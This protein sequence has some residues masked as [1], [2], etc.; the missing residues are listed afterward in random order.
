MFVPNQAV[1]VSS[2][3][4]NPANIGGGASSTGTIILS[5]AAPAGG[6]SVLLT[7]GDSSVTVPTS[8]VVAAGTKTANFS[9]TTSTVAVTTAVTVTATYNGTSQTAQLTLSP[10]GQ[11]SLSSVSVTPVSVATGL[12]ATGTVT[13]SG[14]APSGGTVIYLWTNG[15]PAFVP[16]SI[17]IPAGAPTGTFPVTTNYVTTAT[18]GTITAFYNGSSKTT[19][20][21]VTP[22]PTLLSVVIEDP[23][24]NGDG[25]ETGFVTLTE[26]APAGGLLVYLWTFGSPVFVP[27]SVTVPAGSLAAVFRVTS[28]DVASPTQ[29]TIVAYYNGAVQT[30]TVR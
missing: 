9:V 26:P 10:V 29:D 24:I 30:T 4:F 5:A 20:I 13:L 15:S 14:P 28:I 17:T 16:V 2:I 23:N 11:V 6:A 18:Q 3:S 12:T 27:L 19:T 25:G 8:I 1:T 7:S 21:A 22:A